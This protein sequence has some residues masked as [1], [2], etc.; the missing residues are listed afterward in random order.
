MSTFVI[1]RPPRRPG[2]PLP[3]GELELQEP[4]ALP[5]AQ[6]ADV[7][8]VLT[9]LP[10]GLGSGAT[11][12]M[13]A[14]PGANSGMY[15]ASGL[16]ALSTVGMVFSQ[17]GRSS[18]ERKRKLK[19]E[20]RDYLRYLAQ[21]RR[22]V[23]RAVD[24]HRAAV[25]WDHPEPARLWTVAAG[26]RLWERRPANA[27]FA[28]V[29]IG[30][31]EQ[32]SLLRLVPPQTK[33]VEDLEPLSAG[34]LRRFIRAYSTVSGV[35]TALHLRGFSGVELVGAP[36]ETRG[37]ARAVL[38]QLVTFHAPEDLRVAVLASPD[39]VDT[40]EWTKWLPHLESTRAQ[41]AAGAAR[42][43]ATGHDELLAL[44]GP[45]FANRGEFEP[46]APVSPAEPYT[47]VLCDGV[48]LPEHSRLAAGGLRNALLLDVGGTAGHEGAYRLSLEVDRDRL[49][50]TGTA[51]GRKLAVP[52]FLGQ[53]RSESLAR[54]MS[55]LR[56]S[57]AVDADEPMATDFDLAQ[58]LGIRDPRA[59]PVDALWRP[60]AQLSAQLRVPIG[61]GEDGSV[62]ELDLKESAQGGMGPHGVLIGATGS[63][64]S[65]LLRTL[66]VGLATTHSPE[67]LN[68]VLVDFKG[69]ATFLGAEELPH[70][71]AVITNLADELPLVDRMQDSLHGEMTRRQELLRQAGHSSRL[72]YEKARAQGAPLDPFPT[73]FVVCDEFS[74]LL[75]TKPEFME[76][77]VMIGR[78]GRSLGV[79]LLLASQ[80][81][82]EGRIH[83]LES[84][85]SYRI[86]LRTFSS[87]ESR[88]VIGVADAYE[89]PSA[90]GHGYLKKD[91]TS[92]VRFRAGYVSGPLSSP[93][94]EENP[95]EPQQVARE[96]VPFGPLHQPLPTPSRAA[97]A[98]RPPHSPDQS[99]VDDS[100]TLM[101]ALIQRMRGQGP[102]ARQVWLPPLADPPS[103]DVLLPAVVPDPHRGLGTADWAGSGALR[104]PVGVVD[105]PFEQRRDLLL[106]DLGGAA[107]HVGVVGAP[108]TGKSTLLRTLVLS[109][110]LTHTPAEAQFYCLDFGGGTLGGLAGLPHVGSVAARLDRDRVR[111]TVAELT[112]LLEHRERAFADLGVESMSAYRRARRSGAGADR[113]GDVFLVVD[114]WSTVRQD[115]EDLESAISELAARGL[116]YGVHVVVAATRWSEIRPWLRDLLGT[117]YELRLGDSLESEVSSRAAA[118][119]PPLPG[120]GLTTDGLHFLGALPRLDG[121]SSTQDL[122][123]ATKG[124]VEEIAEFWPGE[125]APEVRLLPAELPARELPPA[126]GDLRV[127]LGLDE[128]RL[129]PV[130]HDFGQVPHLMAFGDAETGKTNLLRLVARGVMER[131]RPDEARILLADPRRALF[132]LVPEEY[133]IGYAVAGDTLAELA[134][135]AAVSLRARLPGADI[136]PGRLRRR[137]W[138]SGPRLF[139]LVDDYD[140]FV[141]GMGGVLEPLA[142]LL[143]HGA[144][145]GFHLVV[146]RSTSGAMRAMMDP[147]LRRMWELGCPGLL[148]SYPREEGKFL[149]EAQPR[150][151]PAGRAQ[152]VTRRSVQ[153]V[154]TGFLAQ[155]EEDS[156]W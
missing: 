114:G 8:S 71:S 61:L 30:T 33:P 104:V 97:E 35:A 76:L 12:L 51:D 122:S 28:E 7:S 81:L 131:Y 56:T 36:A 102:P 137:D 141:G 79:H 23:R 144:D 57:G 121:G 41:D 93:V 105:R 45:D 118:G 24:Q 91:T 150:Q 15:V 64:K 90:P 32:R 89:L 74:E 83:A 6:G 3:Q 134:G 106:A 119:V 86:A 133:R 99:E 117:R 127:A 75:A 92:L 140:L 115:F 20:R 132:P 18:G 47:V 156:T 151:L 85:L 108:Q 139:V 39:R 78:L 60:R 49:A 16:M 112:D 52:D 126:E 146:A 145:I 138:W 116:G 155:P 111:R 48:V 42:L 17:L 80:R 149:G 87:S 54:L 113:Y 34:A 125:G 73:L 135:N 152:F 153:L 13:F 88:S 98:E 65:E 154:Q 143:A 10:M 19:G 44:L 66:V 53:A 50:V 82:D 31:G 77:F 14:N 107:G 21:V 22:Q 130:W 59:F 26:P 101:D 100:V 29:R 43:F 40:W 109:L 11:V 9:Y 94:V 96:V 124:L 2:P 120:R 67:A 37:F 136:T 69:G 63:G 46:D 5:E 70:T 4:P 68:F 148:F 58:L 110:A 103:L 25:D 72:E 129:R 1:S 27:D 128:Q 62:V 142:E 55:P 38:A 95:V 84:H 123:V 147:V